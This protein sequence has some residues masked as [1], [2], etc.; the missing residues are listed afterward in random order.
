VVTAAAM[1]AATA[2]VTAAAMA[3]VTANEKFI[4]A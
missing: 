4:G 2:V 1:A 3:V